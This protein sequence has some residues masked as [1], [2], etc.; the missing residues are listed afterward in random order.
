ME[1]EIDRYSLASGYRMTKKL[2]EAGARFSALYAT[3]DTLA[4]G[5]CRA[6]KEAGVEVPA[7]CSVAGFDGLDAGSIIFPAL[8]RWSSRR[9]RLR[10]L[11]SVTCFS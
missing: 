4:L 10:K 7:D 8:R 6:L 2:L 1:P 3:A 11:R 9:R 5:A